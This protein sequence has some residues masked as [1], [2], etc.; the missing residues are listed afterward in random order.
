MLLFIILSLANPVLIQSY[1]STIPHNITLTTHVQPVHACLLQYKG[2]RL[3]TDVSVRN[4]VEKRSHPYTILDVMQ[5][6]M[7]KPIVIGTYHGPCVCVSYYC[8]IWFLPGGIKVTNVLRALYYTARWTP[9]KPWAGRRSSRL[10]YFSLPRPLRPFLPFSPLYKTQHI[11]PPSL[12][13]LHLCCL[14]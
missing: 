4:K 8:P 1:S 3:Y 14:C 2:I 10:R 11:P 12:H 5:G 6:M 7:I 13:R 9:F